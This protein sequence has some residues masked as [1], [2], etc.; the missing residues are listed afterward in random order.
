[1]WGATFSGFCQEIVCFLVKFAL[2]DEAMAA[3]GVSYPRQSRVLLGFR[4]SVFS[5]GPNGSFRMSV[6][7]DLGLSLKPV[8]E[9]MCTDLPGTVEKRIGPPAPVPPTSPS[10]STHLPRSVGTDTPSHSSLYSPHGPL[11][12]ERSQGQQNGLPSLLRYGPW[13]SGPPWAILNPSTRMS[14]G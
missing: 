11:L 13:V 1:M 9:L 4:V 12:W 5:R 10:Q 7:Q 8:V 14:S 2:K 3:L 6:C